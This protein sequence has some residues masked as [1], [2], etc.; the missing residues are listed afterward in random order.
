VHGAIETAPLDPPYDLA[1]AGECLHWTDWPVSLPR[2]AG[3][4]APGARLAIV[5]RTVGT[6]PWLAPLLR[7]LTERSTNRAYARYDLVEELA[8]RGLFRE[9]GRTRTTRVVREQTVDAYVESFHSRNGFSRD[10]MTADSARAFDDALRALVRE[11]VG[12]GPVRLPTAALVV[13]GRPG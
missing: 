9:E 7:L 8:S 10:R 1:T 3:L 2:L 5:Q 4:L 6:V 13:W 12:D 11:H